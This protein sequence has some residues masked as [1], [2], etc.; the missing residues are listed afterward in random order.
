MT[1]SARKTSLNA[2]KSIDANHD[3]QVVQEQQVEPGPVAEDGDGLIAI[4]LQ[5]TIAYEV[6]SQISNAL[7]TIRDMVEEAVGYLFHAATFIA[8]KEYVHWCMMPRNM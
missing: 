4:E 3:R 7:A 2:G 8:Q 1:R 6:M 5:E